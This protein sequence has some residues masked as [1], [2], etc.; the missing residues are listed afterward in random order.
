MS[1]TENPY[2]AGMTTKNLAALMK[3]LNERIKRFSK[4][5]IKQLEL[6]YKNVAY[7][8]SSRAAECRTTIEVIKK[9]QRDSLQKSNP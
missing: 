1:N 6:G 4:E 5:E 3:D 9:L 2:A 7:D 8:Y